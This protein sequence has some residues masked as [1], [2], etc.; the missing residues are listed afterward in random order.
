[1]VLIVRMNLNIMRYNNG[2]QWVYIVYILHKKYKHNV[3][4][5][6]QQQQQHEI[7]GCIG[8]GGA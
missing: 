3:R 2:A 8:P 1:M 5:L 6:I 4:S 7:N